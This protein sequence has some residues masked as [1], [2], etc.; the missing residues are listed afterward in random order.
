MEIVLLS[1]LALYSSCNL[2]PDN[3]FQDPF[4]DPETHTGNPSG[5]KNKPKIVLNSLTKESIDKLSEAEL[6]QGVSDAAKTFKLGDDSLQTITSNLFDAYAKI[7]SNNKVSYGYFPNWE[8]KDSKIDMVVFSHVLEY[9]TNGDVAFDKEGAGIV[10]LLKSIAK[11]FPKRKLF[12]INNFEQTAFETLL[13]FE[14][15]PKVNAF[16]DEMITTLL[17]DAD[18]IKDS[19]LTQNNPIYL[20]KNEK[21]IE[22]LMTAMNIKS[23]DTKCVQKIYG[24]L[25]G[26]KNELS[27]LACALLQKMPENAVAT[28]IK[29]GANPLKTFTYKNEQLNALMLSAKIAVL[30]E[31][32]EAML[33]NIN[34][35]SAQ[36]IGKWSYKDPYYGAKSITPFSWALRNMNEPNGKL[37]VDQL[38]PKLISEPTA[39]NEDS[40]LEL[41]ISLGLSS[42]ETSKEKYLSVA[43]KLLEAGANYEGKVKVNY[44]ELPVF[45]AVLKA[46]E[47][48]LVKALLNRAKKDGKEASITKTN[49]Q[50]VWQTVF[51][52]SYSASGDDEK[53]ALALLESGVNIEGNTALIKTTYTYGNDTIKT[54]LASA[55]QK[56]WKKFIKALLARAKSEGLTIID[57]KSQNPNETAL[58]IAFKNYLFDEDVIKTLLEQGAS[59]YDENGTT[60]EHESVTIKDSG[61]LSKKAHLSFLVVAIH[62]KNANVIKAILERAKKDGRLNEILE[63]KSE[64]PQS[65][66]KHEDWLNGVNFPGYKNIEPLKH[67]A[68]EQALLLNEK[69]P[70]NETTEIVKAL[71]KSGATASEEFL[72][73]IDRKVYDELRKE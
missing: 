51:S 21:I 66:Q 73:N 5:Q 41:S 10:L 56:K 48:K 42:T 2:S 49:G 50:S 40:V 3:P 64:M 53:S 12:N 47:F 69:E 13:S 9:Y 28:L 45:Q 25:Y 59:I 23:L 71:I 37:L 52:D 39:L 8:I 26:P 72:K 32:I 65:A 60:I 6:F 58:Q 18:F 15:T 46:K 27:Q 43:Q 17:A 38:L 30:P 63:Y 20:A 16:R 67:T 33:A 35:I 19:D 55:V 62:K 34:S 54:L 29:H 14:A 57:E 31:V 4:N 22:Q 7:L 11:N 24:E 1:L 36:S 44:D 61:I 68:L 70:S